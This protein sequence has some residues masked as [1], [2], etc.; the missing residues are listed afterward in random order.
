MTEFSIRVFSKKLFLTDTR[1]ITNY[2]GLLLSPL[3]F[4]YTGYA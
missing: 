1:F 2:K 4:I 3:F